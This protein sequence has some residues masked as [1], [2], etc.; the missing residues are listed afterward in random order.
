[1]TQGDGARGFGC[2]LGADLTR[3]QAMRLAGVGAIGLV[4][5]SSLAACSAVHARDDDRFVVEMSEERRLTPATLSVPR[6]ATVAWTN[7]G[8]VPHTATCDQSLAAEPSHAVLPPGDEPWNS[9][10]LYPGQVWARTFDTPGTYVYFCR[11]HE[12][13]GMIGSITVTA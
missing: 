2:G 11:R 1:M 7:S 10:D 9:G 13:D 5:G 12:A 8:R 4:A 3:R 6:G